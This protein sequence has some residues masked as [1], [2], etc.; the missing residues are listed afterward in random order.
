MCEWDRIV[1]CLQEIISI[2]IEILFQKSE[3][4]N[5]KIRQIS[6]KASKYQLLETWVYQIYNFKN[7]LI[8]FASIFFFAV[9]NSRDGLYVFNHL[10]LNFLQLFACC[11]MEIELKLIFQNIVLVGS[12]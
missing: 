4:L 10:L 5:L 7:S 11:L 12:W 8:F 3:K 1:K 2:V 9:T 6:P